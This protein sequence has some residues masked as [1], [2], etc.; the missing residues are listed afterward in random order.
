MRF[1]NQC[2]FLFRFSS[3][4]M[5]WIKEVEMVN[6]VGELKI[7]AISLWQGFSKLRDAG[8]EN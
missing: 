6:S 5:L 7:I 8:R 3:E 2:E 1:Q 4:A